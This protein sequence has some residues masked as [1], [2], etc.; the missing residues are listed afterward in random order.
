M[1]Y[2]AELKNIPIKSLDR[3]PENPRIFFRQEELE[4]LLVS[5]KKIGLQVP[6]SVYRDDDNKFIIID[7][8]RRWRTFLKLNY[9]SIPAIIQEKPSELENLLL[10][11][12]I[13]GLREQWD[14][15]T[16]ANKIE[17]VIDLIRTKKGS[18]PLEREISAETGMTSG[19]IRRCKLIIALPMRF[20][21]LIKEE[22]QKPKKDQLYSEDFFLE[23][24]QSLRSVT[25]RFPQ[26][27][28]EDN[29]DKVRDIL[30]EKYIRKDIKSV[31]DFRKLTK[32]ATA[33][34]GEAYSPELIEKELNTIFT[35]NSVGIIEVYNETV[36][37]HY[38]DRLISNN[39]NLFFA[40]L[41]ALSAE[42]IQDPLLKD[43][44]LKIRNRIN[45][46]LQ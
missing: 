12:N 29:I 34:D 25:K 3:N 5:I 41:D 36:Q 35:D 20:K 31:T 23:M 24:E 7:G 46:L 33:I 21:N 9:P 14:I 44:L 27:L 15:F 1:S 42:Q 40:K 2:K 43:A 19:V 39:I 11:F 13:H 18:E 16:I 30:I 28:S 4:Q 22:L 37:S 10:M 8:E 6:I 32:I 38:E 26:I 17:R 45:D